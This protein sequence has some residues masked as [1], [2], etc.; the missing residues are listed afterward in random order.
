MQPWWSGFAPELLALLSE[1][2][3]LFLEKANAFA[4]ARSLASARGQALKFVAQDTLSTKRL[5]V[6][7][8]AFI[9]QTGA[10]PTRDLRHDR[11][12][13]LVWLSATRSKQR[14]NALHEQAL[15]ENKV[16]PKA[17][18]V[19]VASGTLGAKTLAASK[20]QQAGDGRGA[21]RD[22]LTLVDENL[23]VITYQARGTELKNLLLNHNWQ[24]LFWDCRD[25]WQ[26]I[27]QPFVF[28]HG[29][30]EKLEAPFKAITAHCLLLA[31]DKPVARWREIDDILC[32]AISSELRSGHL[33]PLPV[34]G[35]PSWCP[36]D[37]NPEFYNDTKVFR[38]KRRQRAE[39]EAQEG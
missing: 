13:A 10:V 18:D 7:Y 23:M 3:E 1:P 24:S 8:E 14:L 11:L 32:N 21:L 20:A 12:N 9:A 22:A 16:E 6:G 29:L 25:A 31:V 5:A 26:G 30:L 2:F 33:L 37:A 27:W 15:H 36:D 39:D 17:C 4:K 35:L 28:G 19:L 34:M 38:P